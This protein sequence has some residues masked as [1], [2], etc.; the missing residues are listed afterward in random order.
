MV[1]GRGALL[2]PGALALAACGG[3]APLSRAE[4]PPG[5]PAAMDVGD[6][7]VK[8]YHVSIQGADGFRLGGELLAADRDALVVLDGQ[9]VFRVPASMITS[10]HVP[11]YSNGALVGALTATGVVGT[12]SAL[13]HGLFFVFS[14]PSWAVLSTTVV[15]T[16]A[17]DPH[18]VVSVQRDGLGALYQY[19]RFPQGLPE[20]YA[21]RVL[22]TGV[23]R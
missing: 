11:L 12:L 9:R 13:T 19:A 18:R 21:Q 2:L 4:T 15:T 10:V 3:G 1:R 8:G 14:G 5:H 22:R 23:G 6:V 7:P 20:P 17:V 16:A